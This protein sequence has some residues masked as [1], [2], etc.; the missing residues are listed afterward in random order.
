MKIKI[1]VVGAGNHANAVHYPSLA[2]FEDVEIIA[3]CDLNSKK[4]K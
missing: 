1:A 3:N 2:S 4:T